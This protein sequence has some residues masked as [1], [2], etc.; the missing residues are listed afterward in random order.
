MTT[1][2]GALHSPAFHEMPRAHRYDLA[3]DLRSFGVWPFKLF[4][5]S[6]GN[7]VR[8]WK[9]A[10]K[11]VCLSGGQGK[12]LSGGCGSDLVEFLAPGMWSPCAGTV[13]CRY[14][15]RHLLS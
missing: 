2:D 1:K 3:G 15:C 13:R 6:H 8:R 14:P 4:K 11:Q 7:P 5:Q 9:I 12:A 10:H